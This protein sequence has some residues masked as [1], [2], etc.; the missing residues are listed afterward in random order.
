MRGAI[1]WFIFA[2]G[3]WLIAPGPLTAQTPAMIAVHVG[4]LA[5]D[6]AIA[7]YYAQRNGLFAKAGLDVQFDHSSPN[8]AAVAAA[9]NAGSYD[10]GK[11]TVSSL[12]DAH[13]RGLPFTLIATAA[14]YDSKAPY[15]GFLVAKDSPIHSAADIKTGIIGL[16]FLHDIGQLALYK[17]IDDAGGSAKG[18]QF[19]ELPMS[20]AVPALVENRV[21]VAEASNP[22]L[23]EALNTGKVRLIPAY[24][25]FGASWT[26]TVYFVT[27]EYAA[28]NAEVVKTFTRVL[29]EA[30]RYTNA[31]HD[32]TAPMLTELSGIPLTVIKAMPRVTNGTGIS[33][34]GIQTLIDA[35]AKYNFIP[36]GF[37]AAELI[38]PD[39]MKP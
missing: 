18:L 39:V 13:L 36:H 1:R 10:I 30:A 34:A 20:S 28:K 31:H 25:I 15:S 24:D 7:L 5:T 17:S 12:I 8:G 2:L 38:D 19:T 6:D 32:E 11:S 23:A 16:Q 4:G 37:P 22:V 35:E 14:V 27:K 33:P 21:Q 9:V 26:F 29:A 3:L